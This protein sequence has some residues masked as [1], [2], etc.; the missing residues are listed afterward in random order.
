MF[1]FP[2]KFDKGV[3]ILLLNALNKNIFFFILKCINE[4]HFRL[5]LVLTVLDLG[6]FDI[7]FYLA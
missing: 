1:L 5:K 2:I 3:L 4:N 6:L 7:F